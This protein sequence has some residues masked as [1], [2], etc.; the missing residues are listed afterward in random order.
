MGPVV[1]RGREHEQRAIESLLRRAWEGR[2]G[3]LVLHGDPGIGKSALLEFARTRATE[4]CVL[5]SVG[6]E[7]EHEL[8]YATLHRLLLP[9]LD[10]RSALP[11]PQAQALGVVFGHDV[12]P[13][14]DRFLVA[15]A[16]L[17]LLSEL[18]TQRP[19][20]CLVDDAHW[21]DRASLET[22]QFVGRRL[23]TEPIA[24]A[25]AARVG[26]GGRVDG[27]GLTSVPLA[28][29]DRSAAR[30]LLV[31]H[32]GD[33]LSG[34]EQD[35]VLR[36][37][38]GNPLAIREF[39]RS[40]HSIRRGEP[41]PLAEGLRRAF[42]D[43][44]RGHGPAALGLLL[45]VAA[46]G[47]ARMAVLRAAAEHIGTDIAHLDRGELDD[48]VVVDGS[49]VM[50]RH[51]LM[52][53]A[54]YHAAGPG[55]RREAHRALAAAL[56]TE[57]A[58]LA[59]RAWHLG[60][61]A[62]GPDELVASE[63][64]RSARSTLRRAGPAAAAV[65]L[66]RAAELSEVPTQRARRLVSSGVCWFHAGD[67][68]RATHTLDQAAG[69]SPNATQADD[70]EVV[71]IRALIEMG[72]RV[73]SRAVAT[74]CTVIPRIPF[75]QPRR[76]FRLIGLLGEAVS[77]A[78]RSDQ[79][80]EILTALDGTRTAGHDID[81][82]LTRLLAASIRA[83]SG[84]TYTL[85]AGDLA[86]V[87]RLTDLTELYQASRS[88]L[89]LGQ[90]DLARRIWNRALRH[91]R[92]LGAAGDLAWILRFA[93]TDELRAGRYDSAEAYAD[94]GHQLA[95]ETGQTNLARHYQSRL[96]MIAAI[97]GRDDQARRLAELVLADARARD[98]P[99]LAAMSRHALGLLDLVAGR[100]TDALR[101]FEAMH[102]DGQSMPLSTRSYRM[103]G[104]RRHAVPDLIEAAAMTGD[105]ERATSL[106][107]RYSQWAETVNSPALRALAA[108]ARAF[109]ES[110][111]TKEH[112]FHEALKYHDESP[113]PFDQARTQLLFGEHLRRQRRRSDARPHLR[114]AL[115]TFTRLDATTWAQRVRQELRAIGES[116]NLPAAGTLATLTP[117]ELRISLAVAQG[118]T[119]REIAGQLFLSPRTVDYH[120]RARLMW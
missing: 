56:A 72:S 114:A 21:A 36:A 76:R 116:T 70:L 16:S 61:A 120:L 30:Q 4:M 75:D 55:R 107:D 8:G 91:G 59:R 62:D 28:A 46:D 19:V 58:E 110:A 98:L 74:L 85:A 115:E 102:S 52:R 64:E 118:A 26:E 68:K 47:T 88:A 13:A 9:V 43:R 78:D 49:A 50:F 103:S 20:L 32:A 105:P 95:T 12:G 10:Q 65:A 31:E 3:G 17:S 109:V 45:L 18:A 27:S 73:P 92:T 25:L 113:R 84:V 117:Q 108:R 90:Y 89:F 40:R 57:P 111:E 41:L 82:V 7:T 51:P 119:N 6:V 77:L 112:Y 99:Q 54:I 24:M 96:A 44:A 11:E 67:I 101:H 100:Y 22:F 71:E 106:L 86:A 60:Q 35:E 69:L 1:L 5:T 23:R 97:R 37:S 53:S 79:L 63:L 2:G 39:A 81:D 66:Q 80:T 48:M 83:Y 34:S 42:L 15:L 104:V 38:A 94:E 87:E 29:L 33:R 14:P 93:V